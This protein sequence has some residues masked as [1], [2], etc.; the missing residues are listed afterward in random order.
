MGEGNHAPDIP[1]R[2]SL[3]RWQRIRD[4]PRQPGN[5]A[6]APALLFLHRGNGATD[7]PV[8][9][10]E[11]RVRRERG[12]YLRGANAILHRREKRRVTGKSRGA[13][14]NFFF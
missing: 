13:G 9:V 7:V 10:D 1:L 12:F 4:V 2:K 8:E 6:C 11:F 14:D 3:H 5:H